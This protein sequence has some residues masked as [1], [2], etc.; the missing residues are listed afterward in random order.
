MFGVFWW[1]WCVYHRCAQ[2]LS[3]RTMTTKLSQNITWQLW[4]VLCAHKT[5]VKLGEL[6]FFSFNVLAI[7]RLMLC[8]KWRWGELCVCDAR[9]SKTHVS[10]VVSQLKLTSFSQLNASKKYN[11]RKDI[12]QKIVYNER[13]GTNVMMFTMRQMRIF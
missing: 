11:M 10:C 5:T 8:D 12:V 3:E 9:W 4:S 7:I 6:F 1:K 13:D 2:Q